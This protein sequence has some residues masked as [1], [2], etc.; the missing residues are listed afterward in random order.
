MIGALFIVV[1]ATMM[2]FVAIPTK[3]ESTVFG[4]V[5]VKPTPGAT[6]KKKLSNYQAI[7]QAKEEPEENSFRYKVKIK[8]ENP[9]LSLYEEKKPVV[10][11]KQ[12]RS[13]K[14]PK[15]PPQEQSGFMSAQNT[16]LAAE[17]KF[18]EAVFRATQQVQAGKALSI[19][20]KEAIPELSLEPGTILQ[21]IPTLAGERIE[22]RV[23]AGI[24]ADEVRKLDLVC[25]DKEDCIE[26]LYHDELAQ[27]LAEAAKE[28]VL[29]EVLNLDFKGK[30]LASRAANLTRCTQSITIEKGREVFLA[31]PMREE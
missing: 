11:T 21:G 26:G 14:V 13:K 23:T 22:I 3:G 2:F 31:I 18:F 4:E 7:K 30:E 20:L 27:R 15:K 24:V 25:F 10:I 1:V 6:S 5:K 17:K 8:K 29:A 16:D 9:L 19:M 12:P 28:G